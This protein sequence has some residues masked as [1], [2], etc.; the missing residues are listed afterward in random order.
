[1]PLPPK[2]HFLKSLE[3]CK[4][5]STFLDAFYDRFL[6]SSEEVADMFKYTDFERQ[7]R[8]LIHSLEMASHSVEGDPEALHMLSEQAVRHSRENL[9]IRP[10]LYPVWLEAIIEAASEHDPF[11]DGTV[12]EAWRTVLGHIIHHM[13]SK[14]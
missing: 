12:E 10:G 13:I 6:S 2:E 1:M 5:K 4:K 7:H 8:M 11:W 14:Y 9:D 3:R